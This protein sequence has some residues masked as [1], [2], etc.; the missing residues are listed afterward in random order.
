MRQSNTAMLAKVG[1]RILK[2]PQSLNARS[3]VGNG[4]KTL[5]W[6]HCWLSNTPLS[7]CALLDIPEELEGATVA[8]LWSSNDWNWAVLNG[9][10]PPNILQQLRAISLSP[11]EADTDSIFWNGTKSGIFTTKSALQILRNEPTSPSSPIWRKI[12]LF[13]WPIKL[14]FVMRFVIIDTWPLPR[15]AHA[16]L[17]LSLVSIPIRPLP[18]IGLRYLWMGCLRATPVRRA[19]VAFSR[20]AMGLSSKLSSS[21]AGLVTPY[22]PSFGLFTM[23][24]VIA[25]DS[26]LAVSAIH[27]P[28]INI[29]PHIQLVCMC[30]KIIDDAESRIRVSKIR[31]S[32]NTCADLLANHALLLNHS[33]HVFD[34][35]PVFQSSSSLLSTVA[36]GARP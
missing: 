12:K 7:R 21:P 20:L 23:R 22:V 28:D 35:S 9:L 24:V 2:N 19:G 16:A 1:W 33:F 4:R 15:N 3:S 36:H 26:L 32:E 10:L 14:F 25:T 17:L 27:T 34:S 11:L 31:R 30:Q 8:D 6:D 18:P 13:L 29:H 5:F